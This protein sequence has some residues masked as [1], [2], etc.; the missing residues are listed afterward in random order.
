[1]QLLQETK[2]WLLSA[3]FLLLFPAFLHGQLFQ[4]DQLSE[5]AGYLSES[6]AIQQGTN[7]PSVSPTLSS[8]GF[9]FGY[10]TINDVRQAGPDGRSLT[11]VSSLIAGATTYK[12]FYFDE[13]ADTD[14]DGIKDW[15]EYR[16]WGDLTNGP[17]EDPDGDGFS[18]Q[19]EDQLGQDPLIFDQVE[20]GGIAGRL[21]TGFVYADTSMV[22]ATIK[23]DPAGFVT[24]TSNYQEMNSSVSTSSLHGATN[25][26]HFAYWSV[27]GVRQAGPTGVAMSKV[28]Q[29]ITQTTNIIAHYLP[30]TEDSDADGVMD[31]FE[32]YQFGN[33]NQGPN[34]DPDEDGFSNKREG[35]LGQEATIVDLVEDGGIAGRLSTGFVYADTSMVLATVKSDPAGFVSESNTYLEQNGSLS[36]SSLHGGTNG[37]HFAY[38]SVNGVR[39]AGPTGVSMSKVDLNVTG[40]TQIIAHYLPSTED[41]DADGVMDWFEL[42]QFGNLNQGPNDDPDG[43]GFSN[44]REGELGQEATIFDLVEDGGIAGRLS[45]GILYFQ[46]Q[47]RP[48]SNLE[49]NSNIAYLNKEA[50][51]TIGTFL[52]TDP[53]DPNLLR[54]YDINCSINRMGRIIKNTLIFGHAT[55]GGSDLNGR[56]QSSPSSSKSAMMKMRPEKSFSI[57]AIHDPNKDDDNDGSDLRSRISA[58]TNDRITRFR[59]GWFL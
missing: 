3:C 29:N 52:P 39:Q 34:D 49:L 24:E 10:W 13:S 6:E 42:Y 30:S 55:A 47:N 33:L 28:D 9:A 16:M 57:L 20:D 46:Q 43:D 11:Q 15:F 32:L 19:R 18:N 14:S 37:Y 53:D 51:Q 8:N 58:G 59:R 26:Y 5:P 22:L 1:M 17:T 41:S 35:E 40:T 54:T 48:P 27:N 38:W 50:N 56:G 12:A 36:T 2:S 44:K 31:W 23:S 45:T 21:S 7:H 25:G 4:V